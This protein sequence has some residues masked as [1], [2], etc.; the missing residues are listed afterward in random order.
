VTIWSGVLPSS[1]LASGVA[2][3]WE[4]PRLGGPPHFASIMPRAERGVATGRSRRG[5]GFAVSAA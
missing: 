2:W 4:L 1:A 5:C 3:D